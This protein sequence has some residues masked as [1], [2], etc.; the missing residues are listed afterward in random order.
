MSCSYHGLR[1]TAGFLVAK[2]CSHCHAIYWE[3]CLTVTSDILFLVMVL[4]SLIG[5]TCSVF[6]ICMVSFDCIN[7]SS[8]MSSKL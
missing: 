8:F 5:M 6:F 2:A 4:V 1:H 7:K 3:S